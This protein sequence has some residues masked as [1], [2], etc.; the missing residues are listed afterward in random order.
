MHPCAAARPASIRLR[1]ALCPDLG[2]V[3]RRRCPARSEGAGGSR[4]AW[5]W[6]PR[7]LRLRPSRRHLQ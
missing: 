1:S 2:H 4:D 5:A 6:P 3:G 7:Q